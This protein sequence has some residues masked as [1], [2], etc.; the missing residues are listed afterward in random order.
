MYRETEST[1]RQ[2]PFLIADPH[3][4]AQQPLSSTKSD[5]AGQW[6]HHSYLIEDHKCV[7]WAKYDS[8]AIIMQ[9]NKMLSYRSFI[10]SFTF[11]SVGL[12]TLT[13]LY[14]DGLAVF[15]D[16]SVFCRPTVKRAWGRKTG[17]TQ[18]AILFFILLQ[19]QEFR[20]AGM[21]I[22]GTSSTEKRWKIVSVYAWECVWV[23][24]CKCVYMT[25]WVCFCVYMSV[26][27]YECE[28][29]CVSRQVQERKRPRCEQCGLFAVM[30]VHWDWF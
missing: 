14:I 3:Q 21:W 5:I 4:H 26:C 13:L 30:S 17:V 20:N 15:W 24:M 23:C 22:T 9:N 16:S 12:N 8:K 10:D 19:R 27:V 18:I 7:K 25:V 28:C 6:L 1:E 29:A 2:F 11:H